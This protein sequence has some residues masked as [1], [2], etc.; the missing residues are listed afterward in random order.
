MIKEYRNKSGY[1]QEK[2]AELLGI[3]SRQLQRIENEESHPSLKVLKKIIKILKISEKDIAYLMKN[4]WEEQDLIEEIG[5]CPNCN[6]KRLIST[7]ADE[8]VYL[9]ENCGNISTFTEKE[10]KEIIKQK[11]KEDN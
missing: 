11:E 10:I 6:K 7:L 3:S 8:H 2:L 4:F 5:N 1:T 9:C